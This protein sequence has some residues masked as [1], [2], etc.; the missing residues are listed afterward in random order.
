MEPWREY[1][2]TVADHFRQ[3]GLD[4]GADV[5]LEGVRTKH[6]IDVAV[7]SHHLGLDILWVVECKLWQTPVSKLHVLALRQIVIDLG[8][9]RGILMAENGFQQ[10]AQ[11]AAILTNVRLSSLA[12]L[13]RSSSADISMMRIRDMQE[14]V[15]DCR[16]RYWAIEKQT[17]IALGLR[18]DVGTWGYSAERVCASLT[19]FLAR[20]ARGTY[21][22]M[23]VDL[24]LDPTVDPLVEGAIPTLEAAVAAAD[25]S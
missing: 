22:L 11:E 1:Q 12:E 10:G 4:V 19:S 16:R 18:H 17:R 9:D 7:R 3:L 14:R 5:T 21:P 6:D 8:A 20:A 13:E 24:D 2:Q 23:P 15:D 25:P